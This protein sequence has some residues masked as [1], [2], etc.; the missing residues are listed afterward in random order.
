MRIKC[1]DC[2]RKGKSDSGKMNLKTVKL[3]DKYD[4]YLCMKCR[5]KFYWKKAEEK[6]KEEYS[7]R[8]KK[9]D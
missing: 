7:N 2:G 6:A 5:W 4:F 9:N 3:L 8:E 1:S